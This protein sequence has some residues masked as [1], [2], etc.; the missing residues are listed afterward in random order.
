MPALPSDST[1][2]CL[3]A[4]T[5][6]R[7]SLC[8]RTHTSLAEAGVSSARNAGSATA[9]GMTCIQAVKAQ[10]LVSHLQLFSSHILDKAPLQDRST[11]MRGMA[12]PAHHHLANIFNIST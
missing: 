12:N 10:L 5:A 8:S 6:K 2:N 9:G 4:H 3:S 11:R 7:G 1:F